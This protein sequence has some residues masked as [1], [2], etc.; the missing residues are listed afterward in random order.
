MT[1]DEVSHVVKETIK[2]YTDVKQ[3]FKL[4]YQG[5]SSILH[6][7]N[8]IYFLYYIFF[9]KNCSEALEEEKTA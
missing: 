3:Y 9:W 8:I 1:V 6:T 5:C 4:G 7:G 2:S